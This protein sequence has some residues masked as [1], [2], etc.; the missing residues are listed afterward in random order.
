M[1]KTLLLFI[2]SCIR[3]SLYLLRKA[4]IR[5][6]IPRMPPRNWGKRREETA[7]VQVDDVDRVEEDE[8][9]KY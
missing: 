5:A 9:R 1:I 4:I 7:A 3:I 6:L 2:S 8:P